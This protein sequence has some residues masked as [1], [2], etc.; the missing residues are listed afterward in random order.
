VRGR[1]DAHG[2]QHVLRFWDQLDGSQRESLLDQAE[3]VELDV[4]ARAHRDHCD[5]AQTPPLELQTVEVECLPAHGGDADEAAR[6]REAGEKALADGRVAA[7]VVA[8]GQATR[9]G[10]PGPKG[11]FPV[12]PV[13]QRTLF[14]QQAQKVRGLRRRYG[15]PLPWYVMTSDTTDAATRE[16]FRASDC[17]GLP[18]ADV[19][20]FQQSMVQSVD[21]DGKLMLDRPDHIFENP[22]GHG[23][24]LT[25][26]L[27]SG[28]LDDMQRRGVD[29]IFYYQVDN[30]L[31]RMADPTYVGFHLTRG[32][33]MSIKVIRKQ[34]PMEKVGVVARA[35][36]RIGIVEYTE[37]DDTNRYACD[38]NGELVYWAGNTAIHVFDTQ[39][40][41]RVAQDA[42]TLLPFHAS[43]KKI[44]TLD[45]AGNPVAPEAPNGLKLERFVFDALGA[46]ERVC[47]VEADRKLDYSPIKNA[48]GGESPD[49]ARSDLLA[50]YRSWLGD[51]GI[52]C[53]TG[54]VAIEIDHSQIDDPDE[55]RQLGI[56]RWDAAGDAIRVQ[57]G[58][59]E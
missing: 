22:N 38:A 18:E 25:A 14:E 20:F 42:E 53:P 33:E 45:D 43:A 41:R 44:P 15:R 32:A 2:Q 59:D 23:G 28:A 47:V 37:I 8:G 50:V 35:N 57:A 31:V 11:S 29:T 16:V 34:D 56:Q 30:P 39:F 27:R 21:F 17:F 13:T 12:G 6:A 58:I 19:V 3:S 7:L 36:G 24:S 5:R 49:T 10:F 52:E 4:L 26:L 46:A 55:A 1:L 48:E 40:V 54:N 9:L 51:A